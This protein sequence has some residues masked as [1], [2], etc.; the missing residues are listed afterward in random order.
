MFIICIFI[1]K[2]L[3][4]H[5]CA[6][7]SYLLTTQRACLLTLCTYTYKPIALAG[8]P[9]T[10]EAGETSLITVELEPTSE[11]FPILILGFIT[12]HEP[13]KHSS[14]REHRELM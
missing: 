1:G 6:R 11:E 9:T 2:D 13:R 3:S 10:L 14:P 5:L 12:A 4:F 7:T 8:L